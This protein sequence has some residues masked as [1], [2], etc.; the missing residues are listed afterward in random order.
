MP[1]AVILF[2]CGFCLIAG[3]GLIL[4]PNGIS[5]LN[6]VLNRPVVS[7]DPWLLRY[8][9]VLGLLLFVVSYA[10]FYVALLLWPYNPS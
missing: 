8:R 2:A 1:D 7:L 10:I 9:H 3:T 4:F 6:L 5:K